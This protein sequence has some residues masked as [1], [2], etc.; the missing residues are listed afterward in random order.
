MNEN[1]VQSHFRVSTV[2]NL[3]VPYKEGHFF[4]TWTGISLLICI[5]LLE[6][7]FVIIITASD[8]ILPSEIQ[9]KFG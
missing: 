4:N 2:I 5:L 9:R 8:E 6:N 3:W 1:R 7:S